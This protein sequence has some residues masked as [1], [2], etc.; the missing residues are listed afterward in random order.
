MNKI[1]AIALTLILQATGVAMELKPNVC[2]QIYVPSIRQLSCNY[3]YTVGSEKKTLKLGLDDS[4]YYKMA[5]MC[6][7]IKILNDDCDGGNRNVLIP[8][9]GFLKQ[10]DGEFDYSHRPCKNK[11]GKCLIFISGNSGHRID[12]IYNHFLSRSEI[13][14][15]DVILINNPEGKSKHGSL[16]HTE[17]R[18]LDLLSA[19][20]FDSAEAVTVDMFSWLDMC[21]SC[22]NQVRSFQHSNKKQFLFRCVSQ[23]KNGSL[24]SAD[25]SSGSMSSKTFEELCSEKT[26]LVTRLDTSIAKML[27]ELV[28]GNLQTGIVAFAL[29]RDITFWKQVSF[30]PYLISEKYGNALS[31]FELRFPIDGLLIRANTVLMSAGL[32]DYTDEKLDKTQLQEQYAK[33]KSVEVQPDSTCELFLC[34]FHQ[35]TGY[36]KTGTANEWVKVLRGNAALRLAKLECDTHARSSYIQEYIT[37]CLIYTVGSVDWNPLNEHSIDAYCE[38][39]ISGKS[40][41]H[42]HSQYNEPGNV[43][44]QNMEMLRDLISSPESESSHEAEVEDIASKLGKL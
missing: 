44:G 6:T 29:S 38:G 11:D 24:M 36:G 12:E 41:S 9:L 10:E 23:I 33:L 4:A 7:A 13:S 22:S 17:E 16:G 18:L 25:I 5:Y 26:I 19:S 1:V 3:E 34:F 32:L 37:R 20:K 42:F 8:Y 2:G 15:G 21:N 28:M 43:E 27:H 39:K 30:L 35:Q 31:I 14:F 40:V